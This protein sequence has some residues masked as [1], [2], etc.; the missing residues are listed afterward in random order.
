MRHAV[1]IIAAMSGA[2]V[3]AACAS[4]PQGA[5]VT[6]FHL[7]QPIPRST[8]A[9]VPADNGQSFSLEYRAYADA[10]GRELAA[11]NFVAV[12][13]DPTSAY[14]GTLSISQTIAPG[15]RRGGVSIG[16]GV[17]GFSGGGYR[18]GGGVG[19]GVGATVPVSGGRPSDIRTTT[20]GL[21]L[22][23]RSDG[24]VVWEGHATSSAQGPAGDLPRA[25]PVLAHAL[26]A[27]FP[28]PAGQ[29]V[30]VKTG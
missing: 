8:V 10:V 29:T 6:R 18:H 23:R 26:L 27:G 30:R 3:L 22:K 4:G 15:P 19:G 7:G 24:S 1:S 21:Q 12:G 14:V 11:Q 17:G 25:V 2:L 13:N 9:L 20:L 28:G 16:F 5:E